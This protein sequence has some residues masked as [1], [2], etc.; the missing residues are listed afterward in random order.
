MPL[1]TGPPLRSTVALIAFLLALV[2]LP[3]WVP[4]VSRSGGVNGMLLGAIVGALGG[5]AAAVLGIIGIFR[6]ARRRRRGRGLAIAAIPMGLV[7]AMS[8]GISGVALS[9]YTATHMTGSNAVR[10]LATS[11]EQ[12]HEPNAPLYQ[13]PGN[14]TAGTVV[15]GLGIVQA[16]HFLSRLRFL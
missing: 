4:W 2:L 11:Q 3:P 16:V 12:L 9:T 8:Q 14:Q 7:A 1:E 6:T 5:L 10:I 15:A 13:T